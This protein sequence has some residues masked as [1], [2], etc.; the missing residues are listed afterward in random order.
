M[1]RSFFFLSQSIQSLV[2]NEYL[3]VR[4]VVVG[5]V[6]MME[7]G[8]QSM[9]AKATTLLVVLS[10]STVTAS[11]HLNQTINC[12][13]CLIDQETDQTETEVFELP[14][15]QRDKIIVLAV[16]FFLSIATYF[17]GCGT[18]FALSQAWMSLKR[19]H[20]KVQDGSV[21][22]TYP[23]LDENSFRL[24]VVGGGGASGCGGVDRGG[25]AYYAADSS[26]YARASP[27]SSSNRLHGVGGAFPLSPVSREIR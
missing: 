3:D 15:E 19:R 4:V 5:Y 8:E 9:L 18:V 23:S 24:G 25:S 6:C 14:G 20:A 17:L 13:Q 12:T 7:R 10:L 27:S 2:P 21:G 16:V 1:G 22:L 11:G 26:P